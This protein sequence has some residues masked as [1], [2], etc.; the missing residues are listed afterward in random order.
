MASSKDLEAAETMPTAMLLSASPISPLVIPPEHNN[1]STDG[2]R[3]GCNSPAPRHYVGSPLIF[4]HLD[5]AGLAKGFAETRRLIDLRLIWLGGGSSNRI[6]A[7]RH[8]ID[9]DLFAPS[10]LH[11]STIWWSSRHRELHG[12][13]HFCSFFWDALR[14]SCASAT[15]SPPFAVMTDANVSP[16]MRAGPTASATIL[17]PQTRAV[18]ARAQTIH[19]AIVR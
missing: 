7:I 16:P 10:R 11:S 9:A 5:K 3:Y 8:G 17:A 4:R 1:P 14:R 18:L 19:R 12:C 15:T 2:S 6:D 13:W